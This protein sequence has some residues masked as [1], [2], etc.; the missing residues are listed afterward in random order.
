MNDASN[1]HGLLWRVRKFAVPVGLC[2]LLA[3]TTGCVPISS[4]APS[5]AMP[6]PT[7]TAPGQDAG[8]CLGEVS[9]PE[10]DVQELNL[11]LP[12][13]DVLADFVQAELLIEK[14]EGA[15]DISPAALGA[16]EPECEPLTSSQQDSLNV[17]LWSGADALTEAMFA[18][19]A[20]RALSETITGYSGTTNNTFMYRMTAWRFDGLSDYR[21]T[22]VWATLAACDDAVRETFL[23]A[24]RLVL[25]DGDEIAIVASYS[26]DHL[27][28]IESIR[29]LTPDGEPLRFSGT[30]SGLLPT[31]ALNTV[32]TW[33]QGVAPSQM[34][35]ESPGVSA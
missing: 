10:L 19:G 6:S 20:D 26:E 21:K 8:A 35:G 5:P 11:S 16:F 18:A 28:L 32:F 12:V 30:G 29:P 13:P 31:N 4:P 2:A 1:A 15:C 3:F 17:M 27:Y 23:G 9:Y 14:G 25:R 22:P 33:W 24:E 34:G 7:Q